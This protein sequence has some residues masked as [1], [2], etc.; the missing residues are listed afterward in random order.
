MAGPRGYVPFLLSSPGPRQ[1]RQQA[2]PVPRP[3]AVPRAR[4]RPLGSQR[5]R[6]RRAPPAPR[7]PVP[8]G[9]VV[10]GLRPAGRCP[11]GWPSASGW[12]RSRSWPSLGARWLFRQLGVGR[13]GGAGRRARLRLHPVPARVHG[14]HLRAPAALGGPAVARRA[15]RC[16]RPGSGTGARPAALGA[17]APPGRRASTRPRCCWSASAPAAVAG[18]ARLGGGPRPAGAARG[19]RGSAVVAVGRVAVVARRAPP[20][21]ALRAAGAAAHREP[22]ARWPSD[23]RPGRRAP[24]PGQLVLLRPRHARG[25]PSTRPRTT[26]ANGVVVALTYAVPVVGPGRR[27]RSSA[28]PIAPSSCLLVVVGTVVVGGGVALRRPEPVRPGVEGLHHGHVARA[29]RSGTAPGRC[30][31]WCSASRR[32]WRRRSPPSRAARGHG[33]APGPWSSWPS[34]PSSPSGRTATCPTDT[35]GPR[36]S[37]STGGDA[38]ADLDA[39]DHGTR[40]LEL[41]GFDLRGLPLGEPGRSAD[42][43]AHRPALPGTGGPARTARRR[44]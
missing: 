9:A 43:G 22:R 25:T 1:R 36:R 19:R 8:G 32:C 31:S 21:G 29:W 12:G 14:P 15:H 10:L 3:G 6:R 24:R 28:G 13:A 30:R 41:P 39:G 5:R 35:T 17:R 34:A 42:P 38:V 11:T 26:T 27:V 33:S 7:L 4:R 23:P 37:P 44:R 40:I 18:P 16:G 2:V 20:P